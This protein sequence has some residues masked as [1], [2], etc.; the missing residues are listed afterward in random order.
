MLIDL[1]RFKE[2]NDTLGHHYGD[3]LLHGLGPRLAECIGEAGLVARLGG[4]EFVVLPGEFDRRSEGDRPRSH[5][6]CWRA[7]RSRSRL[8]SSRS[9]VGASIG[10]TRFPIDGGDL[11]ALLR[12]ADIAMYAAKEAHAASR[13]MPQP[14]IITRYGD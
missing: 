13:C 6:G 11:N 3:E 7:F 5:N 1:D 12:R 8:T 10:I 14:S 9:S 2:I 4:D